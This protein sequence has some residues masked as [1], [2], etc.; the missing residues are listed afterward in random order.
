MATKSITQT[1]VIRDKKGCKALAKALE[2]SES[3]D[4]KKT[5][6]KAVYYSPSVSQLQKIFNTQ[7]K[8]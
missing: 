7:F 3:T 6:S 5:I 2:K 4:R 8:R 1:I